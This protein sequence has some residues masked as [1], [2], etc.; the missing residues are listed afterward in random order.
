[1]PRGPLIRA[2]RPYRSRAEFVRDAARLVTEGG[3]V[4]G[5]APAYGLDEDVQLLAWPEEVQRC[6]TC[7]ADCKRQSLRAARWAVDQGY[8]VELVITTSNDPAH[9]AIRVDGGLIDPSEQAGAGHAPDEVWQGAIIVGVDPMYSHHLERGLRVGAT[10]TQHTARL[11]EQEAPRL[12]LYEAA[13]ERLVAQYPW[14][15][16]RRDA[17]GRVVTGST[18]VPAAVVALKLADHVQHFHGDSDPMGQALRSMWAALGNDDDHL[19]LFVEHA[20][21]ALRLVHDA[22]QGTGKTQHVDSM[23]AGPPWP[24]ERQPAHKNW[25]EWDRLMVSI[26][27]DALGYRV[28][29]AYQRGA[30]APRHPAPTRPPAPPPR[31]P[32]PAAPPPPPRRPPPRAFPPRGDAPPPAHRLPDRGYATDLDP[33]HGDAVHS[34]HDDGSVALHSGVVVEPH[35]VVSFWGD[36]SVELTSGAVVAPPAAA[37][38]VHVNT[39]TV[40][41]V[42]VQPGLPSA[43]PA[44]PVPS[45]PPGPAQPPQQQPWATYQG[46]TYAGLS[47]NTVFFPDGSFAT[48]GPNGVTTGMYYPNGSWTLDNANGTGGGAGADDVREAAAEGAAAGAFAAVQATQG[49]AGDVTEGDLRALLEP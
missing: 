21:T 43:P 10:A 6:P 20:A 5:D 42:P 4:V 23:I 36:G 38:P 8:R 32:A 37:E 27:A 49:V 15:T 35:E 13:G 26:A 14:L 41:A 24:Q 44:L 7:R 31:R 47:P 33:R 45:L 29:R 3:P 48:S 34:V 28:A 22:L 17:S 11:S 9:M 16:Y 30:P 18:Q 46:V 2:L 19:R 40:W 1:M 39:A 25:Q 12:L